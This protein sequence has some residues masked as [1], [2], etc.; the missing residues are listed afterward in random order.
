MSTP[1]IGIQEPTTARLDGR[2]VR[3]FQEHRRWGEPV[4][5]TVTAPVH[6]SLEDIAAVLFDIGDPAEDLADDDYVRLIVAEAVI[7][8]GGA[9]LELLRL[10][11]TEVP[12][13]GEAADYLAHC[14][15][16]AAA[17]FGHGRT[18]PPPRRE[19]APATLAAAGGRS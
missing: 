6:L 16:R 12:N 5:V 18:T 13:G 19:P 3:V 8:K 15:D 4:A 9:Q 2:P 10:A 11:L 17:V 7:N 1:T 14:R